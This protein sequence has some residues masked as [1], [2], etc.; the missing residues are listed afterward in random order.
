MSSKHA[1]QH[2]A[3]CKQMLLHHNLH[4]QSA[5]IAGRG[6]LR[7]NVIAYYYREMMI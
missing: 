2:T 6:L 5:A 7:T 3:K 4:E 1:E